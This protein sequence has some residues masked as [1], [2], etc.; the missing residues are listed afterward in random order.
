MSKAYEGFLKQFLRDLG[1]ITEKVY[2][3][4]RFRIGRALNPDIK[5]SQRNEYWLYDDITKT[6]GEDLARDLWEAWLSCRNRLFHFFPKHDRSITLAQA[7]E[8]LLQLSG[9]MARALN[10]EMIQSKF[11]IDL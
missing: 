5:P 11:Q 10:C 2:Q 9:V 3:S 6:C 7:K 4:R 8:R 1:L